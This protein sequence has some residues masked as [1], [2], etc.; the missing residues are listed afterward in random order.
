[1]K[2]P[3]REEPRRREEKILEVKRAARVATV[4]IPEGEREVAGGTELSS[5]ILS[6]LA[7]LA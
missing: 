5:Q 4:T 3:E 6:E 1:M 7:T 2:A